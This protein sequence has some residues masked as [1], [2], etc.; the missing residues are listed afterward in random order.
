MR[1]ITEFG[2]PTFSRHTLHLVGSPGPRNIFCRID[3]PG[4]LQCGQISFLMKKYRVQR[5]DQ[6]RGS[7]RL[8][9][10]GLRK[11]VQCL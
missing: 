7:P 4:F 11:N 9:H 10:S 8:L 5:R 3:M 2:T 6:R 1:K